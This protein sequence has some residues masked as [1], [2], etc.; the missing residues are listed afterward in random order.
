[1][2]ADGIPQYPEKPEPPEPTDL[3]AGQI[4]PPFVPPPPNIWSEPF[5]DLNLNKKRDDTEAYLEKFGDTY[6]TEKAL[7]RPP[8]PRTP[9]NDDPKYFVGLLDRYQGN[10]WWRWRVNQA[11]WEDLYPV[12]TPEE[13]TVDPEETSTN[14]EE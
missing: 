14:P 9:D 11:T 12:V 6:F 4:P 10:N 3:P 2:D 5:V 1:V 7:E 13:I 8:D